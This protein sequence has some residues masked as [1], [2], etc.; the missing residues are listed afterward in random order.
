MASF[1]EA[2]LDFIYFFYGLAF[3]LLGAVCFAIARGPSGKAA[4]IGLLGLFGFIHGIGEWLDLA[5]FTMGDTKPFAMARTGVMLTSYGFLLEFGRRGL[6]YA[7]LRYPSPWIHL[8]LYGLIGVAAAFGGLASADATG[9]YLLCFCGATITAVAMVVR[10]RTY[11][12]FTRQLS[13]AAAVVLAAYGV[14]AG[15]IVPAAPFFP[16]NVVNTARFAEWTGVP[17]QLPRG[18]LATALTMLMWAIW[19]QLLVV[20]V[21]SSRYTSYLHRQFVGTMI[22]MAAIFLGGWLLTDM[23]GQVYRQNVQHEARGNADLLASR[24]ASETATVEAMVKSMANA[25]VMRALVA[26]GGEGQLPHAREVL[27]LNLDTAG[28]RYGA[29]FDTSGRLLLSSE[30]SNPTSRDADAEAGAAYF[31]AALTG[32]PGYRFATDDDGQQVFDAAFPVR[33][34]DGQISGV[35]V[36]R[37]SL[38]GVETDLQHLSDPFYF[39][40]AAGVVTITNRPA[41]RGRPLWPATP[42]TTDALPQLEPVERP[43]FAREVIDQQWAKFGGRRGFVL[44]VPA[45][46]GLWSLV[47]TIPMSGIFASRFLGIV[48][49]LQ[50]S[51]MALFYFFGRE[52]GVRDNIQMEQRVELQKLAQGLEVQAST[53]PLTG[54]YNRWKFNEGLAAELARFHRHGGVFSLVFYDVDHFK[55]VNDIYGHQTGDHVLYRLSTI[56]SHGLRQTDLLARWGGEEFIVMLLGDSGDA[57]AAVAE[58]LRLMIART[59]FDAAGTVTCSFGVAE[60]AIGDTPDSLIARVDN[61]LYR[62]KLNGRNRVELATPPTVPSPDLMPAD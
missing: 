24:F 54:L 32:A 15:L 51:I 61:A 2:Q 58:K 62:A 60:C 42:Q 17:I 16:A 49:T 25:P 37:K 12:S 6:G 57:A 56:V 19:G 52:H 44:R 38:R 59:A 20:S 3:I 13:V 46:H 29:V 39:I 27:L 41:L 47:V 45:G 31:Q 34:A 8:P 5:A 21:A 33:S 18:V 10:S 50:L 35:A 40:D 55:E 53:D 9:R 4:G 36:L 1:L 28:A 23:L 48:I 26:P 11:S 7:G 30:P 14:L 22:A 43:L